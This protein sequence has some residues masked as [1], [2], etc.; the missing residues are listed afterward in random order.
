ML[1]RLRIVGP[2]ARLKGVHL[3]LFFSSERKL[4]A[5]LGI[6]KKSFRDTL[7]GPYVPGP[8]VL[9]GSNEARMDYG[10]LD[11]RSI[12]YLYAGGTC[13]YFFSGLYAPGPGPW[14]GGLS[15]DLL[16]V[17]IE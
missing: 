7:E 13:F 14:S 11:V 3:L 2:R 10:I 6:L 12:W 15:V 17:P 8:G 5:N 9:F 1:D 4:G 16:P